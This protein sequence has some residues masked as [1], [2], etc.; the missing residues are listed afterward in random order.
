MGDFRDANDR[1]AYQREWRRRKRAGLPTR[2]KP[3][4]DRQP[5]YDLDYGD[6]PLTA[7]NMWCLTT[8]PCPEPAAYYDPDTGSR[9]CKKHGYARPRVVPLSILLPPE[10]K[11][12]DDAG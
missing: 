1:R 6:V 11:P 4:T 5:R 12:L 7:C 10:S 3:Q 8:D 9:W 2:K